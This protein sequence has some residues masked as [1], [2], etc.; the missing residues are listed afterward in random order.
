LRLPPPNLNRPLDGLAVRVADEELKQLTA[1]H[2][3]EDSLT[4]EA[5]V[6][7]AE[8]IGRSGETTGAIREYDRAVAL[9]DRVYG[10]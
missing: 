5:H 2:G 3:P 7:S 10:P 8:L 4:L 1:A 6:R 9:Y